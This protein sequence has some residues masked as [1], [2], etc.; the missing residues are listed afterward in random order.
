MNSALGRLN[1]NDFVKGFILAVLVAALTVI[2]ESVSAGKLT[3][4]WNILATTVITAAVA[5]LLKNLATNSNGEP[6]TKEAGK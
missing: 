3:V 4:D 5:Y 6:L 2:Q 1:L